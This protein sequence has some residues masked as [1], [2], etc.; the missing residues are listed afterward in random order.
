MDSRII[1]LLTDFGTRD[2]FVGILKGVI[3]GIN[4]SAC[5]VDLGHDIDPGDIRSASFALRMALPYFP[6][7]AIIAA[8][9]DPGVGTDR[10]ALGVEVAG[11]TVVCPDNGILSWVLRDHPP[12]A[13]VELTESR[14]HLP[15]VSG[16]FHGRDIFAPVAA[17]LSLGVPL[18][19]FGPAA[20]GLVTLDL[21]QVVTHPRSIAG[22]VVYIDRFGN[23]ITNIDR[24]TIN[25][26]LSGISDGRVSVQLGSLDITGI[27]RT[28]G[29]VLPRHTVAVIGSSGLLEIGVNQGD[30]AAQLGMG[31]GFPVM[32]YHLPDSH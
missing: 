32:V 10:R 25:G 31:V 1:A 6:V 9:I 26:W 14:F 29:D 12:T 30:A 8:V 22:Q 2:P 28:Y 17:H 5:L 19:D 11:R 23:L 7:G 21:P 20:E 15:E 4:P 3:L 16:T 18:G 27:S 24:D 13:A